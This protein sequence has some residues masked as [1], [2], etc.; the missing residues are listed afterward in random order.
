MKRE[1]GGSLLRG[2]RSRYGF[3]VDSSHWNG[4]CIRIEEF[5]SL[6]E[7]GRNLEGEILWICLWSWTGHH[8][9]L[10]PSRRGR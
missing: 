5:P 10:L 8:D 9:I 1:E 6:G 4:I 3:W 7:G 2:C